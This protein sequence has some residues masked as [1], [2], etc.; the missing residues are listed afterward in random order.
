MDQEYLTC[1]AGSADLGGSL[2]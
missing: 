2:I 1:R